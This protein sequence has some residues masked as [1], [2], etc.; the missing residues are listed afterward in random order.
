VNIAVH[1]AGE[2]CSPAS[3]RSFDT[4]GGTDNIKTKTSVKLFLMG[5][6]SV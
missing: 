1:E 2:F 4:L 3:A 5:T 6:D